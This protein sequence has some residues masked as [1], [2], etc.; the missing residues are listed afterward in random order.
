MTGPMRLLPTNRKKKATY[1]GNGFR[2]SVQTIQF[3]LSSF[4]CV[5]TSIPTAVI[6]RGVIHKV[7]K[8]D[9]SLESNMIQKI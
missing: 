3:V 1:P 9:S 6:S 5:S 4:F 7:L 2:N 8:R